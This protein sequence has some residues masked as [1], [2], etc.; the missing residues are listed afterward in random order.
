MV[1]EN[2]IETKLQEVEDAIDGDEGN[3]HHNS[4]VRD[5]LEWVLGHTGADLQI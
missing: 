5:A 3:Y 2:I 1:D 4:A